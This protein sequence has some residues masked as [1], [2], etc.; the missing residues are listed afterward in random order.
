MGHG[1]GHWRLEVAREADLDVLAYIRTADGF[2]TSV[3]DTMPLTSG[4]YEAPINPGS[5]RAQVSVLRIVNPDTDQA[6][7]SITGVDDGAGR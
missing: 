7:V 4:A 5:N 6:W 3:H 2:V 1:H